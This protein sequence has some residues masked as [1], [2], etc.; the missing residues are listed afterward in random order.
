MRPR[1]SLLLLA[2]IAGTVF[3]QTTV[4]LC[5]LVKDQS[6]NPLTNTLVRLSVTKPND[7]LGNEPY[8]TTT[9]STGYYHIGSGTCQTNV[10]Q[11]SSRPLG[12]VFSHPILVGRELVFSVPQGNAWVRISMFDVAGHLVK[13]LV[14]ARKANG[15]YSVTID[16]RDVS[17]QFYVVRVSINGVSTVFKLQPHSRGAAVAAQNAPEFH[18][19]L[20]KLAAIVDTIHATEP[21]YSLGMTPID[22]T[23]GQFDFVLT[24]TSTW[25]GDTAAFWGDT[26]AVSAAATAN[27]HI[28]FKLLNKT[29][30]LVPDSLIYWANGDGGVPVCMKDQPIITN[31]GNGRIYIMIGYNAK[32]SVPYRPANKIWDFE[33]HNTG[34]WQYNGNLTRVDWF[35]MP[36]AMRLHCTDGTP[37]LVRGEIYP[38]FSQP[39]Q[40]IFDEFLNEVPQDWD[41]CAYI[42]QPWKITNPCMVPAFS[43]GGSHANYWDGY[44]AE[45]GL[46]GVGAC[47]GINDPRKS[48]GLYRHVLD[49][50]VSQDNWTYQYKKAP[51]TFYGY[52]LHRRAFGHF[53]YTFPYDDDDNWSSYI[54]HGNAHW[55]EIAVGY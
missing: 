39:R 33:E 6:G 17:S 27:G 29:N 38:M 48:S 10:I 36:L 45:C 37:D 9:D 20:K 55:L 1:I 40:T 3:S 28:I 43:T 54:A 23:T 15:S 2:V 50:P 12:N 49:L 46:T 11:E 41:S 5:G 14:N 21:G 44:A 13:D 52:F 53:Q 26:A 35:G 24:K 32:T 42:S 22:V 19:S 7:S 30:G 16:T 51:C 8:Y 18:A 34:T 25:D 47:V 4:N 31:P